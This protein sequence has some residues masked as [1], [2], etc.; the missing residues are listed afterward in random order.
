MI[1]MSAPGLLITSLFR[2]FNEGIIRLGEGCVATPIS[3]AGRSSKRDTGGELESWC[4]QLLLRVI[5]ELWVINLNGP[6][7]S[8][9]AMTKPSGFLIDEPGIWMLLFESRF[10]SPVEIEPTDTLK[11]IFGDAGLEASCTCLSF[12][13]S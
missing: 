11:F 12:H 4:S 13:S 7:D 2:V 6:R 1:L 9:D 5:N 3:G 8:F 10:V